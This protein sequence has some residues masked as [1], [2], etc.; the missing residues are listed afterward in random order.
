MEGLPEPW[1]RARIWVKRDDL[2]GAG[3]TKV[4][5]L[6]AVLPRARA[7][8]AKT[9]LTFGHLDSN[10]A[11]ATALAARDAGLGA[12]LWIQASAG[13]D[14]PERRQ[15]FAAV[16][17]RVSYRKGQVGLALGA[18]AAMVAG[19]L[20]GYAPWLLLP[21]GTTPA[22]CAA[23]APL[24]LE[25][26]LQFEQLGEPL[27]ER[28]AAAVGSGGTLAGLWAGVRALELPCRLVGFHASDPRLVRP[29]LVAAY[30]NAALDRLG[31]PGHLGAEDIEIS[32]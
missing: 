16:A 18:A 23:V 26:A 10:H 6:A 15:A 2:C 5:K 24:V 4:R 9:V 3:G 27:P 28:W 8:G 7:A 32:S 13:D 20:K 22:T 12:E 11:L 17:T 21:G 1:S 14:F 19:W 29:W 30:A 25:V 31:L